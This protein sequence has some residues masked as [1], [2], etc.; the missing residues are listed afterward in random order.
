[1]NRTSVADPERVREIFGAIARR[2]DL[3]NHVLS[4]GCDFYWRRRAAEI[5]ASWRPNAIVDLA[6][7]TGDLALVLQKKIPT[8]KIIGADFSEPMLAI[9]KRKGVRETIL[10]NAMQLPFENASVDVVTISFGL[11]NLPDWSEALREMRRVLRANGHVLILEFSLPT[12]SILRGFYRFYLHRIVPLIGAALTKEK[13][14]YDYLGASI[15]EFPNGEAML[16]LLEAN[17]FRD[18]MAEPLTAGIVTV[19]TANCS[20]GL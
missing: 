7:G 15:E 10:A 3:A 14:A 20:G 8:A 4:C 16:R 9:A 5:V 6:C 18:A 2:Y 13:G 12:M 11:R 1:L 19:Y 17:G